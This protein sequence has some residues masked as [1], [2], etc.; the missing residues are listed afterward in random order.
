MRSKH[1]LASL[2]LAAGVILIWL[3]TCGLAY[4]GTAV[5]APPSESLAGVAKHELLC[6]PSPTDN[7]EWSGRADSFFSSQRPVV[8]TGNASRT[9]VLVSGS[10]CE[11]LPSPTGNIIE[12]SPSQARQLDSIVAGA[13]T[14]DTILLN[15]GVYELHGDYLWVDTPGLSIRSKSGNRDAVIIDGGYETT[16]IIHVCASNVTIA[17]ITLKRAYY[18]P[19]H[20][21]PPSD[22]DITNTII[23]NV[24]IIDLG[25]QAIKINQNGGHFADYGVVACS[26][27]ELTDEGRTHIRNNCYSRNWRN[28]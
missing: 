6:I 3:A 7:A 20:V 13:A 14:G 10:C 18:H 28:H 11:P 12:V 16:E 1:L 5:S 17:D 23:Y 25:E 27:I 8:W 22:T 15:D 21:S 2:I 26:R 19:I 9:T 24:H 4:G